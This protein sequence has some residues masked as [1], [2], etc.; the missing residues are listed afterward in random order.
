VDSD[1]VKVCVVAFITTLGSLG[2]A[3]IGFLARRYDHYNPKVTR[4]RKEE[5]GQTDPSDQ[6]EPTNS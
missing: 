1:T 2:A 4:G 6:E 5:P 3:Y